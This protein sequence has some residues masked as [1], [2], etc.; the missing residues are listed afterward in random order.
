[1]RARMTIT[2]RV[3]G[4]GFRFYVERCAQNLGLSGYAR[5]TAEG[6][7]V[8]AEGPKEKLDLLVEKCRKGPSYAH[9]ENVSVSY[10][11]D[12]SGNKYFGFDIR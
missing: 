6:V 9:V 7:E 1:M 8:V 12:D 3:Q 4:V 2:G 5:N 11:E 10:D